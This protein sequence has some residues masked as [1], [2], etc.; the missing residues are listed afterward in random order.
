MRDDLGTL[1]V[2]DEGPPASVKQKIAYLTQ[3]PL[4]HNGVYVLSN[5][6]DRYKFALTDFADI[7]FGGLPYGVHVHVD[8]TF[9]RTYAGQVP[10]LLGDLGVYKS[11][12]INVHGDSP[13]VTD[14]LY[15]LKVY[16]SWRPLP[17][18]WGE[19]QDTLDPYGVGGRLV[20]LVTPDP[21]TQVSGEAPWRCRNAHP[22]ERLGLAAR[23]RGC[24][25]LRCVD[26]AD[27][28]SATGLWPTECDTAGLLKL[29]AYDMHLRVW[30]HRESSWQRGTIPLT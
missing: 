11:A 13:A 9:P 29:T 5:D 10:P 14:K 2:P 6:V 26:P 15:T 3:S 20:D 25:L 16:A 28:G 30:L 17:L 24:G 19:G 1:P 4:L 27:Q 23:Q 21:G 8:K 7:S 22:H 12:W 18:D